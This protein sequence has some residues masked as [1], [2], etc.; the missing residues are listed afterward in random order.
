MMTRKGLLEDQPDHPDALRLLG[1][2]KHQAGDNEMAERM[3][4]RSIALDPN[5]PKNYD[6]LGC[7][8]GPGSAGSTMPSFPKR[9]RTRLRTI[10]AGSSSAR[11]RT[12]TI[13]VRRRR[14]A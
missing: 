2:L 3:V 6:N 14:S 9:S 7:V 11:H 13:P 5:N 4:R 12:A 10:K 8:L 1:L